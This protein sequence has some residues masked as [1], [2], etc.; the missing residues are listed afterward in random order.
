[1]FTK[2]LDAGYHLFCRL[3]HLIR[4]DMSYYVDLEHIANQEVVNASVT[5][6]NVDSDSKLR[7]Y[8]T[9]YVHYNGLFAPKPLVY[10]NVVV[11]SISDVDFGAMDLKEFKLFI[12]ML[13]EG[14]CDNVHYYTR[15]E[16]LTEGIRRIGNDVDYY[17]F[18]ETGYSDEV[19]LTMNVYIDHENEVVL[20]WADMEVLEDDEGQYFEPDVDDDK[21]SQLSDD[22]PYEHEV[23]GYI[24]SLDKIVGDE[25]L[26]RVSGISKDKNDDL[27]T[28]KVE[29][30]NGDDKPMYSVH[31]ENQ[32]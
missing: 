27:E 31:N 13:I 21:D 6:K 23:N 10:L 30:N 12:A 24:P 19:G 4:D 26:H 5:L 17:E 14:R 2:I 32:K 11:A 28:D 9:V 8:L 7:K 20:D 1:M 22:I 3:S 16:P 25:F 15:N 29:T 18:I